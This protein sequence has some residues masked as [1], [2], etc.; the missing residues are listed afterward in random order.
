MNGNQS[1]GMTGCPCCRTQVPLSAPFC[2][3]CGRPLREVT[4]TP[5]ASG[6]VGA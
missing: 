6:S 5:G 1:Q 3:G 4:R 2:P